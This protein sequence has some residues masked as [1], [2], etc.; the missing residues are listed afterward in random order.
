MFTKYVILNKAADI[1]RTQF[2]CLFNDHHDIALL[3]FFLEQ[4]ETMHVKPLGPASGS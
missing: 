3:Q 2:G 1:F 4:N